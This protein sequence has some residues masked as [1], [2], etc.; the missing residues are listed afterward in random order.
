MK[1]EHVF[2]FLWVHGEPHELLEREIEKI[3]QSNIRSFC[4]ESRPHE[5]FCRAGWWEDFGFILEQAKKRDM[6]VWLLDD[7]HYPTGFANGKIEENPHLRAMQI[8]ATVV[9]VVGE[10]PKAKILLKECGCEEKLLGVFAFPSKGKE[11]DFDGGVDLS[12]RAEDGVL[13][14]D[15]PKGKWRI[16]GVFNTHQCAEWKFVDPLNPASMRLMIDEI[17][18]PHY[19]HFKEYFGNTF[20]GFFSDEPRFGNGTSNPNWVNDYVILLGLGRFGMAYPWSDEVEQILRKGDFKAVVGLWQGCNEKTADFRVK[21][22]QLITDRYRD[23]FTGMLG[24]WCREHG[25]L[26]TGHIIEDHGGHTRTCVSAGHYF[27]GTMGQ[28]IAGVDIVYDMLRPCFEDE[29]FIQRCSN[30]FPSPEFFRYTLAKLASSAAHLEP[31]KRGRAMCEIFGANGWAY[32]ISEMKW[33][34][35]HMLSR[36]INYFVPHAFNPKLGDL[37]CPPYFY[38]AGLN[39]QYEAFGVLMAYADKMCKR[40]SGGEIFTQVAL[41]YHAEAE[42]SG[43]PF[44]PVDIVAKILTR[45]NIPFDIVTQEQVLEAQKTDKLQIGA[46]RYDFLVVPK[47]EYFGEVLWEKLQALHPFVVYH[48]GGECSLPS[49]FLPNYTLKKGSP[50]LRV[51]KYLKDGEATYTVF[52]EGTSRTEDILYIPEKGN[53]EVVDDL[54]GESKVVAAEGGISLRL[55]SGQAVA[56]YKTTKPPREPVLVGEESLDITCAIS[57]QGYGE[58]EFTFYKTAS[59]TLD[60][61][62]RGERPSFS[63]KIKYEAKF[64]FANKR[65]EERYLLQLDNKQGGVLV[66]VNDRCL[67]ERISAPYLYDVTECLRE[68][69]NELRFVYSTTAGLAERDRYSHY[70]AIPR[71]G[72]S[73]MPSIKRVVYKQ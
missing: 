20:V 73:S 11:I 30:I 36:G 27:K 7:K 42:W 33:L 16:F 47:R 32:D 28:D 21:Y 37:D 51:L 12:D 55:E 18:E 50:Y 41:L 1:D 29:I 57:L 39:P 67:G 59:P 38:N 31:R 6:T 15:I 68:G 56:I 25:V 40:I 60:I 66:F 35:G 23:N 14:W 4:V 53:Y 65:K 71:Y 54:T 63:G 13:Y 8:M 5:E 49:T 62:D 43:M 26:Y 17:Y 10:L 61:A 58:K 22:M 64:S 45:K 24:E 48:T 44:D 34:L 70:L 72:L 46:C 2:P 69:E 3:Y 9:D 52:N 19:E